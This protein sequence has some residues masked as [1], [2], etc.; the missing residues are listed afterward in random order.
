MQINA[1]FLLPPPS[2]FFFTRRWAPGKWRLQK[3]AAPVPGSAAR[4]RP[5]LPRVR[6]VHRLHARPLL[7]PAKGDCCVSSLQWS[8]YCPCSPSTRLPG[9]QRKPETSAY[10]AVTST[11][12]SLLR[13]LFQP[14]CAMPG[15]GR[16]QITRSSR[17]ASRAPS[18]Q[19]RENVVLVGGA[20]MV[21]V[22]GWQRGPGC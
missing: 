21:R 19:P 6:R 1:S 22:T 3:S 4:P 8:E 18:R 5:R 13:L 10:R 7:G 2:S 17:C 12:E 9:Q 15:G 14:A 20:V 11:V 16:A